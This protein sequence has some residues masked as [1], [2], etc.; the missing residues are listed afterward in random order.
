[1]RILRVLPGPSW[2]GGQWSACVYP[3]P[4]P[5]LRVPS[6]SRPARLF[7]PLASLLARPKAIQIVG[8]AQWV[9]YFSSTVPAFY[10]PLR[11]GSQGAWSSPQ[12]KP[13]LSS[14]SCPLWVPAHQQ[15][16]QPRVGMVTA[17]RSHPR[18]AKSVWLDASDP[19]P[20]APAP[21]CPSCQASQACST[22]CQVVS[23]PQMVDH[24]MECW[25]LHDTPS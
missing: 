16:R 18:G 15:S 9:L 25:G 4:G 13:H 22:L 17:P 2:S 24:T 14:R 20:L 6:G 5:C 7:T 19:H 1:M 12:W 21:D 3:L 23:S 11:C 10:L 8:V